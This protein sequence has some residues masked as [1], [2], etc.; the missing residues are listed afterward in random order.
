MANVF[1]CSPESEGP[2]RLTDD[3]PIEILGFGFD[4]LDSGQLH[5]TTQQ[6]QQTLPEIT[7]VN[8]LGD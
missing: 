3:Q 7:V 8:L 5:S 6:Q 1:G 2:D 4:Q